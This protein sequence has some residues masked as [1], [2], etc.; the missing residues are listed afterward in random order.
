MKGALAPATNYRFDENGN[1]APEKDEQEDARHA[2][3]AIVLYTEGFTS[4]HPADVAV[5]NGQEVTPEAV[6]V[7][8][9]KRMLT[10]E[11]QD[12][13]FEDE[14]RKRESLEKAR[15]DRENA[16][17]MQPNRSGG[18]GGEDGPKRDETSMRG[19]QMMNRENDQK[20][21]Q[22]EAGKDQP[23]Y[24]KTPETNAEASQ[25]MAS[26]ANDAVDPNYG[27]P[28]TEEDDQEDQSED[29][30]D[31]TEDDDETPEEAADR[32]KRQHEEADESPREKRERERK[33]RMKAQQAR[34]RK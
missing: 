31:E 29:L 3:E 23:H 20:R 34:L 24:N 27:K 12:K 17:R 2:R 5:S 4:N 10:Q 6:E 30:Q 22:E 14:N 18:V 1:L 15:E 28:T 33:E 13:A 26:Q 11:E 21:A 32:A 25:S 19:N 9:Q 8:G 7:P 16:T